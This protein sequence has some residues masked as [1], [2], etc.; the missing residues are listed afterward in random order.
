MGEKHKAQ[1]GMDAETAKRKTKET[2]EK[3]N[4]REDDMR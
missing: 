3:N 2:K 1:V 4:I